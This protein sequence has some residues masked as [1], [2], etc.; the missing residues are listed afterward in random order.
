[1]R[2][3]KGILTVG[4]HGATFNQSDGCWA[5]LSVRSHLLLLCAPLIF[6][7]KRPCVFVFRA[8]ALIIRLVMDLRIIFLSPWN[9]VVLREPSD[10][11]LQKNV[12]VLNKR[13]RPIVLFAILHLWFST[14]PYK[15][16][17][18]VPLEV[19]KINFNII[20]PSPPRFLK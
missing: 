17:N 15:P 12:S 6:G 11:R 13:L 18:T 19:F 5:W 2:P 14:E 1:V 8:R 10:A 7:E 3:R 9:R 4:R 16:V 20:L